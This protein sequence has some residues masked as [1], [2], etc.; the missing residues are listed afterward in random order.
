MMGA[1]VL[2]QNGHQDISHHLLTEQGVSHELHYRT[3][4]LGLHSFNS[5]P[6]GQNG[7]LF[8]DNIFRCILKNEKFCIFDKISLKF[9][10][11]GPFDNNPALVQIMVRRRIDDKPLSEPM[12]T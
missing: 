3:C 5:S 12:L 9:V 4:I 11:E 7:C 6:L 2:A 10:P 1:D 8:A